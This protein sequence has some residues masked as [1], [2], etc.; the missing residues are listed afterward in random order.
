VNGIELAGSGVT[1]ADVVAVARAQAPVSLSGAARSRVVAARAVVE[2]AASGDTAI[3]GLTTALGAN[4]GQPIPAAER[5]AYQ[6]RAVQAR[7]VGVGT[8]FAT[9]VVR[10]TMFA[11][12]SSNC[13]S[14]CSMPACIPSCRA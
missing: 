5:A 2:R 6:A 11:R 10:A 9:D 13:C 12:A 14:R 1:I 8:P 3:Y 4:T 7:A